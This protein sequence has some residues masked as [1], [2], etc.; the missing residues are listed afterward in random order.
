[1]GKWKLSRYMYAY[2]ENGRGVIFSTVSGSV[3]ELDEKELALLKSLNDSEFDEEE[4][5]EETFEIL[6]HNSFIVGSGVDEFRKVLD[7]RSGSNE[8]S[9][10]LHLTLFITDE[11]CM[12]CNYC[13]I[14][15]KAL[16]FLNRDVF[17]KIYKYVENKIDLYDM[18]EV[19]WFGGEPLQRMELLIEHSLMFCKLCRDRG[20][21]YH[22]SIV[23]NGYDLTLQ[24]AVRLYAAGIRGFQIT[25]DGDEKDHD[26]V[27]RHVENGPSFRRVFKNLMSLRFMEAQDISINVRC[28]TNNG[29]VSAFI[30]RYLTYFQRDQRFKL[31]LK[32]IVNYDSD[33][34]KELLSIYTDKMQYLCTMAKK[35]PILDEL[36][37]ESFLA[38]TRWCGTL[39]KHTFFVSPEG[40][41]YT[42]D[43][44]VNNKDYL[45]GEFDESGDIVWNENFDGSYFEYKPDKKCL[46]CKKF[47]LCYGSCQ[48]I[49]HKLKKHSCALTEND[50]QEFLKYVFYKESGELLEDQVI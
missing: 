5:P 27:R 3:I 48:R 46:S 50:M 19:S 28:N 13:F 40:K 10:T 38:K 42:C 23:T 39:S 34:E 4:M 33:S 32:P 25:F 9:N 45:L 35:F 44:T 7:R 47:P 1:M 8:Q 20:K 36:V 15:K 22:S 37:Q 12:N 41:I 17:S 31:V 6:R 30:N 29:S 49:Y 21:A 11:C 43:S 18:L 14:N 16:H 2:G 26:S 24:N